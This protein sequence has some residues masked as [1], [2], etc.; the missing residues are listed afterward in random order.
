MNETMVTVVGNAASA[1]ESRASASGH[2]VVRLRLATTARRY[3]GQ[4]DG[5][6]DDACTSASTRSGRS[7]GSRS[8]WPPP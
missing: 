3:D 6:T 8:T 1:V 2:P 4:R 5:W 7:G